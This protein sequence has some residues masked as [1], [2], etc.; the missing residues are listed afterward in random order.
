MEIS[1]WNLPDLGDGD[2]WVRLIGGRKQNNCVY[3]ATI[4]QQMDI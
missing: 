4:G 3:F 2:V 1:D